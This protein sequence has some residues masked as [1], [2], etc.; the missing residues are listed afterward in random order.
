MRMSALLNI[1]AFYNRD[2]C[3]VFLPFSPHTISSIVPAY[4]G[5][6]I[7]F[8]IFDIFFFYWLHQLWLENCEY[9][10]KVVRAPKYLPNPSFAATEEFPGESMDEYPPRSRWN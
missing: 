1:D 8:I 2:Y 4:L 9:D 3:P 6:L 10:H 7:P 5:I